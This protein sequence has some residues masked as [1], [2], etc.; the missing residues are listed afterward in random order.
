MSPNQALNGGQFGPAIARTTIPAEPNR[1]LTLAELARIADEA[2]DRLA[3]ARM[4]LEAAE[5]ELSDA[6]LTQQNATFALKNRL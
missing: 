1:R 6:E 2:N 5:K 4:Q 3:T